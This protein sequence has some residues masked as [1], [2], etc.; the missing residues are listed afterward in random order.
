LDTGDQLVF[1]S[2]DNLIVGIWLDGIQVTIDP[3]S[4]APSAQVNFI[5]TLY[6]DI[7]LMRPGLFAV[8][9]DSAAQ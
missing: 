1:G 9:V 3:Y 7:G 2:W 5:V 8:S 4:N 6:V